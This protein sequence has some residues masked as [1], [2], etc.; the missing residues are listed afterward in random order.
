[1]THIEAADRL[2][3]E[4]RQGFAVMDD[5]SRDQLRK[6][7]HEQDVVEETVLLGLAPVDIDEIGN[8]LEGEERDGDGQQHGLPVDGVA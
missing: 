7:R 6:E 5:R 3:R 1:M 2:A 8:L 4:L